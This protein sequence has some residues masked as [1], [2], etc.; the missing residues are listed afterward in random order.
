MCYPAVVISKRAISREGL[1]RIIGET[2]FKVLDCGMLPQD[3]SWTDCPE[4]I[5]TIIECNSAE[6]QSALVNEVISQKKTARCIVLTDGIDF[7]QMLECFANKARGYLVKDI[8]CQPLLTSMH[9]VQQGEIVF[10]S[11]MLGAMRDMRKGE[12]TEMVPGPEFDDANLSKREIDV[13]TCLMVGQSNK[14]IARELNLSEATVKVHVKA[15]L[16]KLNVGNRTQAA[17]WGTA[18]MVNHLTI[19]PKVTNLFDQPH[20]LRG[21]S[22]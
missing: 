3:I 21:L 17:M 4:H 15:I 7:D 22:R 6:R 13:L 9:L 11:A 10:P 8:D 16:R 5:I 14:H 20:Q 2:S 1:R 18:R 19:E 12:E